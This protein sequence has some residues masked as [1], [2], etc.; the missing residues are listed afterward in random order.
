MAIK[1]DMIWQLR[2]W[3]QSTGLAWSFG[4]GSLTEAF[5]NMG[6]AVSNWTQWNFILTQV[7]I[8]QSQKS[9]T[10]IQ[11]QPMCH[12]LTV[13]ERFIVGSNVFLRSS[14]YLLNSTTLVAESCQLITATLQYPHH[15]HFP[16]LKEVGEA[17]RIWIEGYLSQQHNWRGC[18]YRDE[19][20]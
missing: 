11:N 15:E 8:N 9:Y 18:N 4:L 19:A 6:T 14:S 2:K 7:S 13:M 17:N 12:I 20:S 3:I 1:L 10:A 16:H 5:Q